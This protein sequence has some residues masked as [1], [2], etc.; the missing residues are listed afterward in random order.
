M[1]FLE[2]GDLSGLFII[3]GFI[4]FGPPIALAIVGG[5]IRK[6]N[7]TASK[8]LYILAALY[9]IVGLGICGSMLTA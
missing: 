5:A 8:V 4:M 9:L 3:I 1:M 2:V 6:K 7:K